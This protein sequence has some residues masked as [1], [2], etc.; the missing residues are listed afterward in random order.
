MRRIGENVRYTGTYTVSSY[1]FMAAA[2][3]VR[4][5]KRKLSRSIFKNGLKRAHSRVNW[6]TFRADGVFLK[7]KMKNRQTWN[8]IEE[9]AYLVIYETVSEIG[10]NYTN[11]TDVVK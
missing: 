5:A 6:L 3:A 11:P 4:A 8:G 1:E 2:A 9:F 10:I 7:T